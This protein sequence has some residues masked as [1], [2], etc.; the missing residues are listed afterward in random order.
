MTKRQLIDGIRQLNQT[1]QPDFLLQFDEL[2]LAQYLEHL[3]T[4]HEKRTKIEGWVKSVPRM[5][6]RMVS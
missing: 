5:K 4:A 1:A 6:F 3:K 2:A